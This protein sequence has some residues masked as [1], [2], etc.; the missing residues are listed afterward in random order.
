MNKQNILIIGGGIGGL[1]AAIALRKKN[2]DVEIIE[3]DPDWS[4]YGVGIIQQSNVVRAVH[5][6]GILDDYLDAGF[7][8]DFVEM[9]RPDGQM[10]ARIPSP[11]LAEGYPANVGINRPALHKVLGDSAKASGASIRL[12]VTATSIEETSGGVKVAFTDNTE[13]TY[14]LVVGADG[15]FSDTRQKLFPDYAQP[16]YVGQ[17]VWRY[18]LPR[19]EDMDA[20]RAFEGEIGVGLVPLSNEEMYMY[21][22]TPEPGNPRYEVEGIAA[23]MR[24]KLKNA[25]PWIQELATQ[26]T[27][28]EGVVYRPLGWHFKNDDWHKGRVV[29]LGD[30]VHGTTPHLGQGAGMAI[31]DGLVLA[32]ELEKNDDIESTFKAYRERRFD[33]CK[34]IVDASVSVCEFQMGRGAPIDYAQ[35]TRDM[36]EATAKPL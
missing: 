25:A 3:K 19:P 21:V 24:D 36:F 31:E 29:L 23:K 18:N 11:K 22:T 33:R 20:L 10:V 34:F 5:E 13:Q 7:G 35:L 14:D 27:D 8:F 6:L 12:G 28:D 1:C 32:D 9:Y 15:V 17:A 30:A 16:E 2:H 4:V 26:I